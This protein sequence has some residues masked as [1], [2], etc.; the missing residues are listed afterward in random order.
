MI[1]LFTTAIFLFTATSFL[2]VL[3]HKVVAALVIEAAR[4]TFIT[5]WFALSFGAYVIGS[6]AIGIAL[7]GLSTTRT[8]LLACALTFTSLAFKIAAAL[9]IEAAWTTLITAWFALSFGANV[10]GSTAIAIAA[11]G[12]SY[13]SARLLAAHFAIF[14]A[15]T[16]ELAAAV[17]LIFATITLVKAFLAFFLVAYVMFSTAIAIAVA[18]FS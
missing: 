18:V 2:T 13:I 1:V 11:A 10:I 6:T 14:S 9:V 12:V 3:T 17:L 7:A 8:W 15:F 4:I 5:A 16:L